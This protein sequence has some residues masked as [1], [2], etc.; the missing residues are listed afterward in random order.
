MS[1]SNGPERT[2]ERDRARGTQ[3]L[4]TIPNF[5]SLLRAVLGP[6]VLT[7]IL[8][9]DTRALWVALGLMLIAELTDFIDGEIARR[10]DQETELGRLADPVCD[11]V[12]HLSVFLAF[13]AMGWMAAWMLFVIYARDLMVPYLRA[14]ARQSGHDLQ[15]LASGKIKT[16]VHAVAQIGIVAIAL[17][18]F[19]A[20]VRIDGLAPTVL[21]LAAIA[22]SIYSLADYVAEVGR[23]IRT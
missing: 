22:A 20:D 14:F 4:A 10:Y 5:L 7:L 6:V 18:V 12:Y 8:A 2:G 9:E 11:S 3:A 17:G 19:G 16:A 1:M 21:L 23:L 13:L 15:V